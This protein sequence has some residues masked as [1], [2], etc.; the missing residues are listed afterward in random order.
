MLY[1]F[2]EPTRD[3]VHVADVARALVSAI[4]VEGTFNI[5]TAVETSVREVYDL[6]R[7]G[8]PG[9]DAPE[10]SLEPLRPGELAASCLSYARAESA[11]GWAPTIPVGEGIPATAA[12]LVS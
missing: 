7:A 3:Y 6:V 4:G 12:S 10:P 1:G 11:L 8:P 2:G 9:A 5:G